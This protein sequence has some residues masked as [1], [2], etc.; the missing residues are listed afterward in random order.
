ME[1]NYPPGFYCPERD[2]QDSRQHQQPQQPPPPHQQHVAPYPID[3]PYHST[4]HSQQPDFVMDQPIRAFPAPHPTSIFRSMFPEST[5]MLP[6]PNLMQPTREQSPYSARGH[7]VKSTALSGEFAPHITTPEPA[8]INNASQP[9]GEIPAPAPPKKT[10]AKEQRKQVPASSNKPSTSPPDQNASAADPQLLSALNLKKN[11][12]ISSSQELPKGLIF[13]V[14]SADKVEGVV[15]RDTMEKGVEFGP[16]TGTL[17]DEEQGWSKETSWEICNPGGVFLYIDG[18]KNWMSHIRCARSEEEQNME[19]YQ[20]YGNIYFRSTKVIQPG[21]E[22]KVFYDEEYKKCVGMEARFED[23]KFDQDS[24]KFQCSQCEELFTSTKLILRHIRCEHTIGKPDEMIAVLTWKKKKKKSIETDVNA[25]QPVRKEKVDSDKKE[26]VSET[27]E[28]AKD[29]KV[30]EFKCGTCGKVFPSCGRLKAHEV[31]HDDCQEHACPVCGK[32]QANAKTLA[33]HMIIHEPKFQVCK[34]CNQKYKTRAS[35]AKHEMDA[36]SY[37][38]R[39]C[40]ERFLKK[41]HCLKH[42]QTHQAF[43]P[44]KTSAKKVAP[45]AKAKESPPK[46]HQPSEP[47]PDEPKDMLGKGTHYYLQQRPFKCRFCPKRYVLRKKVSEHER[48]HHTGDAAYKCSYCPK[49]FISEAKMLVH[50]NSHEQNRIYRC[51]LCPRTFA[52]ES[53]LNNHQDEHTG[54]KPIK[55]EICGKGFRVKKAVAAHRRRM[56]QERPK[57]FFCSVCDKGF[58]DKA[59]LIKH[60]RRHKGI[61]PYVCLE[62]GKAFTGNA[63]LTAHK[64][65]LHTEKKAFS[66]EICNKTFSLNQHYTYHMFK[67]RVKEDSSLCNNTSNTK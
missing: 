44:P 29:A 61:R 6:S 56:H 1:G 36:H 59:N 8:I 65:A 41:G 9:Q 10:Q 37:Q 58:C 60:E 55:C 20:H 54:L 64:K 50:I 34:K 2:Q 27:K 38:C 12:I 33:N 52:S 16:Y 43:K 24:Q 19:A 17:L 67:H 66:C 51:K 63:A 7:G 15:A 4:S 47:S 14:A 21:S 31:F 57:R 42:E 53:A 3:L 32:G 26:V 46:V 5:P 23:L 62:C 13:K 30:I 25:K 18:R 45:P 39:F 35:L 22:L 49:L 28:V 11:A 48:E 40:S